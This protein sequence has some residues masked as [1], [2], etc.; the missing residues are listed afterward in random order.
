MQDTDRS[1]PHHVKRLG[2]TRRQFLTTSLAGATGLA[3]AACTPPVSR[4]ETEA[5]SAAD[6]PTVDAEMALAPT[7]FCDD[8]AP[9]ASNSEGPFYTPDTPQRTSLLEPD[10][11]GARLLLTGRVLNT[12]CTPIA[13]ALLDFWHADSAGHYDNV[14][15]R[16][17]GHQFA[18]EAGAYRLETVLPGLYPGRTRHIHVKVAVPNVPV[19]TTQLYFPNEPANARDGL[20]RPELLVAVRDG[21]DGAE[22]ATFDFVLQV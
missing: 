2:N 7:P 12:D 6:L 20:F 1:S 17:R 22:E 16:L 15:F 13:G 8:H 4:P 3:L 21:D 18:D 11:D 19:L 9:T 10:M 14:G 5:R